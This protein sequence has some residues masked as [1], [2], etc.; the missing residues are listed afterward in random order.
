[1][2]NN[3]NQIYNVHSVELWQTC[4]TRCH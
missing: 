4:S 1:M 3:N 2:S